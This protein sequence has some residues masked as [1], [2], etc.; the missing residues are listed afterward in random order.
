MRSSKF[1]I[2]IAFL[3]AAG[4]GAQH[5]DYNGIY[6]FPVSVGFEYQSLSPFVDYEFIP[7]AY[8]DLSMSARLPLRKLPS[9]QLLAKVGMITLVP[10]STDSKWAHTQWYA[11]PGLAYIHRFS[12][13]IEVGA[14]VA[15]GASEAVFPKLDPQEVRGSPMLLAEVGARVALDPSFNFSLDVHPRVLFQRAFTPVER[16]NGASLGIG[17]SASYRFGEDPDSPKAIVRSIRF[18]SLELPPVYPAM[19]SWY[20]NTKASLGTVTVTNTE[21]FDLASVEITFNQNGYMDSPTKLASIPVLE[22]GATVTVGVNAVFSDEVFFNE[23]TKPLTGE[24][25]AEYV[26]R[27][28]PV[29]QSVPLSYQLLDRKSIS[30]SDDAKVGAFITPQDSA[31]RNLMSFLA[32]DIAPGAPAPGVAPALQT[33]MQAWGMLKALRC[34]YIADAATPFTAAQGASDIVDSVSLARET[35]KVRTGDCD[36]LA[37]LFCSLL[38]AVNIHTACLLVP[39]HIYP[40]FDTGVAAASW[41]D[42]HPEKR[43][44][45]AMDGTLW[46]PVEA[47]LLEKSDFLEAWRRG[48][49]EWEALADKPADRR[50]LKVADA[51]R[52]YGPVGLQQTDLGLQYGSPQTVAAATDA[53]RGASERLVTAIL[54]SYAAAARAGGTK[55]EYNRFGLAC[56]KFGRYDQAE[57][58]FAMALSLDRAYLAALLNWGNVMVL[59]QQFEEA[60]RVYHE[61]EE[62]VA[63]GESTSSLLPMFLV[64]LSRCYYEI[65]DYERARQYFERATAADPSYAE[66][67]AYL[68]AAAG[69]GRQAAAAPTQDLIFAGEG[70]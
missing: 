69:G 54:D 25:A 9:L 36:D 64:N 32:T 43:M 45:F 70:E 47:T 68:T 58:A 35:L 27:G 10:P 50:F 15:V 38:E 22:A 29:R 59:K 46:V 39:G 56:A 16:F 60:L 33:A 41:R 55:A 61:G 62:A 23:G 40:A 3:C 51:Q 8:Y 53:A 11:M 18:G 14:E 20:A 1:L 30:W 48:V 12:K 65:E 26:S 34:V 4:A 63:A 5:I 67:F 49:E 57:E 17:F 44:T 13:T 42:V 31:L 24:L 2:L 37:V 7:A 6:R 28:R 19:Q 21:T 66:R 52:I